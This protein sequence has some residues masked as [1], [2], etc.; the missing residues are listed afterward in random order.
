M[1]AWSSFTEW[2]CWKSLK[3]SSTCPPSWPSSLRESLR[4]SPSSE[5]E[6]GM[7]AI[8]CLSSS[9][10]PW[11]RWVYEAAD[12]FSEMSKG[13]EA[14]T[15]FE[16]SEKALEGFESGHGLWEDGFSIVLPYRTVELRAE[17]L[18]KGIRSFSATAEVKASPN[19]RIQGSVVSG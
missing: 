13:E 9:E 14:I 17:S 3:A 15:H 19:R 8:T 11:G 6:M 1:R 12:D 7:W 16:C 10:R 4:H 2:P 5:W 18:T